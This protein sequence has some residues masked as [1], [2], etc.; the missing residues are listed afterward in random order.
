MAFAHQAIKFFD[1]LTVGEGFVSD[2]T[3]ALEDYTLKQLQEYTVIVAL[4]AQPS[5]AG[6]PLFEQYME[7]GGGWLGF[8]AAAY[9]D[10]NTEWPW[11]VHKPPMF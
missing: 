6:R 3:Q 11:F 10:S 7:S 2:S 8:H 1:K 4:N 9:N 5:Q